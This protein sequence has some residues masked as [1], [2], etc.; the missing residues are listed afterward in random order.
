MAQQLRALADVAENPGSVST[1]HMV[2][3]HPVP[4]ALM[5]SSR[6]CRHQPCICHVCTCRQNTDTYCPSLLYISMT[7]TITNS[8]LG[9]KGLIWITYSEHSHHGKKQGSQRQKLSQR[10]PMGCAYFLLPMTHPAYYFIQ[11]KST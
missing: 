2:Y 9:R 1:I 8:N 5:S 10:P 7:N 11:L 3:S 4:G 6:L